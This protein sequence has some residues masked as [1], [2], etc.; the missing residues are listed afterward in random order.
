RSGSSQ[1]ITSSCLSIGGIIA[2]LL[3]GW[4]IDL[5]GNYQGAFLL[6]AAFM[7][8]AVITVVLFHHPDREFFPASG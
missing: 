5:T 7:G 2:P 1:G 3:T 6:L 4:M 8:I